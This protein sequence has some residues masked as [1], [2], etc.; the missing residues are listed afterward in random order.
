MRW[1]GRHAG[2]L[3]AGGVLSFFP[4]TTLGSLGDAGA[5]LT[6]DDQ[7]A[8]TVAALTGGNSTMDEIQAAVLLA[9]LTR[10]DA[11]IA[12]RATSAAAYT[13]RLRGVPGVRRLPTLAPRGVPE[14]AVFHVYLIEV[15][16]RDALVDHLAHHGVEAEVQHPEPPHLQPWFGEARHRRGELPRAEA[17][18]AR[19][20]ALP[21]YPDLTLD[22]VD[23]VCDLI[24]AFPGIA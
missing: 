23:V 11:D 13:E 1:D 9:K 8:E 4:T 14:D 10:L 12:R 5:V 24:R 16:Y 6:D 2:L 20:L 15:D 17:A 19:T 3:G 22:D 21:L 18:R 7:I